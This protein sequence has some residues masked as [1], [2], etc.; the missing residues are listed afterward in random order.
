MVTVKSQPMETGNLSLLCARLQ[1]GANGYITDGFCCTK[2]SKKALKILLWLF[3]KRKATLCSASTLGTQEIFCPGP[4]VCHSHRTYSQLG[5]T[6]VYLRHSQKSKDLGITESWT[7]SALTLFN[8]EESQQEA[9]PSKMEKLLQIH[10]LQKKSL[11]RMSDL[12]TK[13]TWGFFGN[14][15]ISVIFPK[16]LNQWVLHRQ[17]SF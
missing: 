4:A 7:G 1:F 5:S 6:T 13:H 17:V 14:I 8:P 16:I 10:I 15:L 12:S 11:Y 2:E 9:L 3:S